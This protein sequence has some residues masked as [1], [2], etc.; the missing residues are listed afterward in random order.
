MWIGALLSAFVAV[1]V[2]LLCGAWAILQPY[3]GTAIGWISVYVLGAGVLCLVSGWQIGKR[4]LM[5][6]RGYGDPGWTVP[7][8]LVALAAGCMGVWSASLTASGHIP[9]AWLKS[10]PTTAVA[11]PPP[12]TSEQKQTISDSCAGGNYH[13]CVLA[14]LSEAND[15]VG[16]YR[17]MKDFCNSFRAGQD[18]VSQ[19]AFA[20]CSK[21][22]WAPHGRKSV[23]QANILNDCHRAE[24]NAAHLPEGMRADPRFLCEPS[25]YEFARSPSTSTQGE[26]VG[27]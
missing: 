2:G 9:E 8:I 21:N 23:I 5:I 7:V 10:S 18:S 1:F 15:H 27:S 12:L 6:E 17:A 24:A 11:P 20:R 4:A 19:A 25:M 26:P 22:I 3:P 13:Q 16:D 14:D